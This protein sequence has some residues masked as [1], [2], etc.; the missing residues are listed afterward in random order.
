MLVPAAGPEGYCGAAASMLCVSVRLS[1]PLVASISNSRWPL[2]SASQ[3]ELSLG[4]YASPSASD[5]F[6]V[7][8]GKGLVT[9]VRASSRSGWV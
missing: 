6:M 7:V 3:I 5:G 9:M 2:S 4:T 1:A 8:P